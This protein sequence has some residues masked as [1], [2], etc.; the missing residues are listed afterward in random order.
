M[1]IHRCKQA[2]YFL[3]GSL[4]L[5]AFLGLF[6]AAALGF[7][8]TVF[9]G[10]AAGFLADAALGFLAAFLG[11]FLTAFLAAGFLAAFLGVL[12]FLATALGFL[13]TFSFLGLGCSPSLKEPAAP[14]ALVCLR[15]PFSTAAFRKRR[16]EGAILS[17]STL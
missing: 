5:A 15:A 10:L 9:L 17:M 16:M 12:G 14:V 2:A 8:A 6:L 13:A 4:A 7:L 11:V 3:A 1:K